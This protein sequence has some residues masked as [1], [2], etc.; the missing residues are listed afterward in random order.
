MV[1]SNSGKM[2]LRQRG[3]ER[4][5]HNRHRR[6]RQIVRLKESNKHATPAHDNDDII[7]NCIIEIRVQFLMDLAA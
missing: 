1:I 2:D 6:G 7:G 5:P 3:G 4:R